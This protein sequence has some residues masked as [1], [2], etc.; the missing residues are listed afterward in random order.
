M[1]ATVNISKT[2]DEDGRE[3]T[4]SADYRGAIIWYN[5]LLSMLHTRTHV[6]LAFSTPYPFPYT[7]S[8]D[9]DASALLLEVSANSE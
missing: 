7:I 1:L 6:T 5:Q 3:I 9:S 2:V 4:P 8:A